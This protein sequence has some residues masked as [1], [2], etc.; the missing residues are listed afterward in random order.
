[1][2]IVE[3]KYYASLKLLLEKFTSRQ[4]LT[5]M[6]SGN[7]QNSKLHIYMIPLKYIEKNLG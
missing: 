6:L 3:M 2:I 1:M 5:K 4:N 7:K